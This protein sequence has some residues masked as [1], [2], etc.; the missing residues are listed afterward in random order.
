MRTIKTTL[1]FFLFYYCISTLAWLPTQ[2]TWGDYVG[3]SPVV[4]VVGLLSLF[5]TISWAVE[6]EEA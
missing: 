1:A 4:I 5:L 3:S 2:D 6:T